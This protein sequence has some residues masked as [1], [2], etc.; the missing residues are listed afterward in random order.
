[1]RAVCESRVERGLRWTAWLV[2]GALWGHS[3]VAGQAV[4]QQGVDAGKSQ[5]AVQALT[6]SLGAAEF[7][8]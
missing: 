7:D 4:A 2:L 3:L 8:A 5:A 6:Q 1:M